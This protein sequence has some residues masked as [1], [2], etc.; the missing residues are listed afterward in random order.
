MGSPDSNES[1]Q[2][3]RPAI[4][5]Q[6]DRTPDRAGAGRDA[7][8][9]ISS[10]E[11]IPRKKKAA[12]R[13]LP[14]ES[15]RSDSG[16]EDNPS[17]RDATQLGCPTDPGQNQWRC[18]TNVERQLLLDQMILQRLQGG[19]QPSQHF[20][21]QM[22]GMLSGLQHGPQSL[23]L[24]EQYEQLML[25]RSQQQRE[26][27]TRQYPGASLVVAAAEASTQPSLALM[28]HRENPRVG[29]NR[30]HLMHHH[31]SND[32]TS[33]SMSSTDNNNMV[34]DLLRRELLDR[35]MAV[36]QQ[37][38]LLQ[39]HLVSSQNNAAVAGLHNFN[40]GH[41]PGIGGGVSSALL[42]LHLQRE[43]ALAVMNHYPGSGIMHS[44]ISA[45]HQTSAMNP[46]Q[47][48]PP[49]GT[50]FDPS[51][52]SSSL[53]ARLEQPSAAARPPPT[54]P[55]SRSSTSVGNAVV[56]LAIATD[57]D[58]LSSYQVLVREQMELFAATQEDV[59]TSVQGRKQCV[60]MGQVGVRCRHC[61]RLPL[62]QRG[63]GSA[64]YPKKLKGIY[65]AVQNMSATHLQVSCSAI[66]V[67]I[68]QDLAV[69][70][71]RRETTVGG[72]AYW[73]EAC[74]SLGVVE[75]EIGLR[76]D[77]EAMSENA[78]RTSAGTSA[79]SRPKSD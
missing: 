7:S 23:S 34:A 45:R 41:P 65:Q 53:H 17:N 71:Q 24:Q 18:N 27:P 77:D 68:R 35:E 72:K 9:G 48:M 30:S 69:L 44:N 10:G 32:S 19:I 37:R 26:I 4:R 46:G 66:P 31:I 74:R 40:Y 78:G 2:R 62:R 75:D 56:P 14:S 12:R 70:H 73:V 79:S 64:Y 20:D 11:G 57:F 49:L 21:R 58:Q 22:L 28:P 36:H 6:S 52:F 29:S 15:K 63:R 55:V 54:P 67:K 50:S 76:F 1:L 61:A 43:N 13:N 3:K 60:A 59:I 38:L 16:H 8:E 42:Q 33:M 51:A 39:R 25:N 47:L 5:P